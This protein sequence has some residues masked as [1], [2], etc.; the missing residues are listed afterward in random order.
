VRLR[1]ALAIPLLATVL[2]AVLAAS[3]GARD[4]RALEADA[5][6]G[7]GRVVEHALDET[8]VPRDPRR[9]V[10]LHPYLL[11]VALSLGVEPVGAT[12]E[13]PG[14]GGGFPEYLGEE[15]KDI[16][17][18]GTALGYDLETVA[19]LEPDLILSFRTWSEGT[20]DE[21][22]LIAPTVI[23][24]DKSDPWQEHTEK[25]AELLGRRGRGE[26]LR[27]E[28]DRRTEDLRDSFTGSAGAPR[29]SVLFPKSGGVMAEGERSFAGEIL[30]DA[31]F[32]RPAPQAVPRKWIAISEENLLE[33]D[34]DYLL[35]G[36]S[37]PDT[38]PGVE[39]LEGN[40]LWPELEAVRSGKVRHVETPVWQG[41]NYLAAFEVIDGLGTIVGQG[42]ADVPKEEGANQ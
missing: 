29:L 9:V 13:A 27:A 24:D 4:D 2:A 10:V 40:P 5:T 7:V 23:L 34:A 30:K 1:D 16:P 11:A 36:V 19:A 21:L 28:Y 8:E 25:T 41:D 3:C 42:G 22:S 26:E 18:V 37:D 33:H 31:G 12:E 6:R 39:M 38:K 35:V 20:Y 17:S 32:D 15:A 14:A